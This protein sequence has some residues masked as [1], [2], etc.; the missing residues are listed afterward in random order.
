MSSIFYVYVHYAEYG[1]R[2]DTPFYVGKGCFKRCVNSSERNEKWKRIFKK[3]GLRVE[4]VHSEMPESDAFL[5]EMWLIAK[6]RHEGCDL[7]N[8]TNGG[9]GASGYKFTEA[10]R[11]N[12]S[13]SKTG[14][15]MSDE[16]KAMCSERM[17]GTSLRRGKKATDETKFRISQA[18]SGRN[19]STYDHREYKF[20]NIVTGEIFIGTSH[21]LLLKY[22]LTG[23]SMTKLKNGTLKTHKSWSIIN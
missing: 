2:K 7:A 17:K 16:Y 6:F 11:E 22:G 1:Y 14:I 5:L 15:K 9:D 12:L 18:K 3:Y 21:D 10:Q 13:K 23:S 4:V 20:L 19:S 8:M